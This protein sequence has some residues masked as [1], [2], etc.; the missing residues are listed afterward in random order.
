MPAFLWLGLADIAISEAARGSYLVL[1]DDAPLA[2][3]LGS[4]NID[5]LNFNYLRGL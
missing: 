5:V 1:T 2:T 4:L 3:H